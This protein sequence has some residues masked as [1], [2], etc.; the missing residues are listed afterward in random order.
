MAARI[1]GKA[2]GANLEFLGMTDEI[3]CGLDGFS[4]SKNV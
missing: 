1:Y 2:S 3:A 4:T